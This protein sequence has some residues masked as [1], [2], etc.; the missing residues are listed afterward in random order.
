MRVLGFA[1]KVQGLNGSRVKVAELMEE[2]VQISAMPHPGFLAQEGRS[3]QVV[4]E[5]GKTRQPCHTVLGIDVRKGKHCLE[6]LCTWLPLDS[7]LMG[8]G[9]IKLC[10]ALPP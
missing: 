2:L 3:G 6:E 1:P 8:E 9:F 4:P 5:G 10:F 7:S